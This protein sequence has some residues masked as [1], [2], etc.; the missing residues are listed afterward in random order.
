MV[1]SYI[2]SFKVEES[3]LSDPI[4]WMDR[5]S[6][7]IRWWDSLGCDPVTFKL[8][9]V[10]RFLT[11]FVDGEDRSTC[12]D[13]FLYALETAFTCCMMHWRIALIVNTV[14]DMYKG[15]MIQ[16]RLKTLY[17][18]SLWHK[19]FPL[20]IDTLHCFLTWHIRRS[21]AFSEHDHLQI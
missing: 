16:L 5:Q 9:H 10:E 7:E 14:Q 12:S 20:R 21:M 4:T 6:T 15:T 17:T 19:Y 13:Q 2:Q 11:K 18:P 3:V 8:C 1:S